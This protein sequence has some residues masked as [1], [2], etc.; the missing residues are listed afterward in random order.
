MENRNSKPDSILGRAGAAIRTRSFVLFSACTLVAA[1]LI[2]RLFYLQIIKYKEYRADVIEQ[3]IYET[4]V[5]AAR[6]TITDRNGVV[7]ATNYTTERIFISPYDIESEEERV[8]ICRGLSDI[9]GVDYDYVYEQSTKTKYK[10]RTIKKNVD[11]DTADIVRQYI[12]DNKLQRKIC[13]A[14]MT[15]RVY[16]FSTLAS[17][18][19]GFCGTDGGSYGLEYY[20]N[21]SLSGISGKI[22]AAQNGKGGSMPYNYETYIDA[23]NGAN[24]VTTI[25][26]KIQSIVE[27]YLEQAAIESGCASRADAVAM[28]P[29]TGEIYAMATYPNYDLNSPTTLSDYYDGKIAAAAK[30]YGE[31]SEDYK[32]TLSSFLLEMWNNKSISETYEPGSTAKVFTTSMALEE[33]KAKV[34][35][36]FY[37]GGSYVV[38]GW[39]IKCHKTTGH[40]LVT[41]AEGLKQSCNPCMMML[42]ERI[43]ISLYCKYFSAF[44]LDSKTGIDLPGETSSVFTSEE[45]MTSL[46]L[47]VYSFGQRFN[48]TALQQITAISAVANGGTLVTPHVVKEITSDTGE[49]LASF[50]TSAKRQVVSAQTSKTICGILADGV[51]TNGGAKNAYVAGYSVAAK[52]GTS[53]KGTVGNKRI[54]STVAFAPSYDAQIIIILI[55]DEPTIGSIYGSTVAAPY[56]AKMLSEILPYLGVE[57]VYTAEEMAKLEIKVKNYRGLSLD[58]AISSLSSAGLKYEIIG[59]GTSV[60]NQV[61]VSGSTMSAENGK[62]MLYTGGE[63]TSLRATVPDVTGKTAA[64][65]NKLLAGAGFNIHLSGSTNGS[66]AV[67]VSQSE[68]AGSELEKGSVI[69]VEFRYTDGSD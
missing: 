29:K 27:N 59:S 11:E 36:T 10:D 63:E 16:P 43:G 6:G 67:A 23:S 32:K 14:E 53:E 61:P 65:A 5:S 20:Y 44:G 28:N 9:L 25:D 54:A 40:G 8:L 52:T 12:I 42:G 18:V 47:A 17:H 41:F 49:V 37:C 19:I 33:N 66:G 60:I 62:V 50:G 3:M 46:D 64:E 56:V 51:A 48:V 45:N 57:P 21:S 7:L 4:P 34:T 1:V 68:K 58:T 39:R 30:E 22:V 26:Y 2:G 38:S 13:L 55:V 15:T 69:T 31:D 35:D 24:L